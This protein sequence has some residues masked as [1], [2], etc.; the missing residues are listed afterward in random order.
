MFVRAIKSVLHRVGLDLVRYQPSTVDPVDTAFRS[1]RKL[2]D[3]VDYLDA[4]EVKFL[5]YCC[6]KLTESKSQL[7][8]DLFVLFQLKEKRGGYFVEF[9]ACDGITLSNTYL[10]E[11]EFGWRGIVAEPA[12]TW[13][14]Q[15]Q[16][17]RRCSIEH[18]C[19]WSK[20]GETLEF[21]ETPVRELSTINAFSNHDGRGHRGVRPRGNIYSVETISLNDLLAKHEAPEKIDYL[22]IDTEGSELSIL[23]NFDFRRWQ[24]RVITVEHNYVQP[25]RDEIH[26][27]MTANGYRSVF[28]KFSAVD[29]WY[30]RDAH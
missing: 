1:L 13:H 30:V 17:N 21:N 18:R 20:S 23:R 3:G 6:A 14:E 22:S 26:A 8:Q 24:P 15:L 19:V 28:S 27:L 10:L 7:F 4:A 29:D 25:A 16:Q 2:H 5:Q 11:R 12:K 9:G